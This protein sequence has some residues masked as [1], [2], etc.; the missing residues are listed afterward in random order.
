HQNRGVGTVMNVKTRIGPFTTL[1]V[2]EIAGWVEGE[3]IDVTHR[4]VI[5]GNG[6]LSVVDR[7]GDTIVSWVEELVFPW[8]LGGGL[9]AWIARP[10]LAGVWRGNL[11][12]LEE[13]IVNRQ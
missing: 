3:S 6:T 12:R 5:T 1:D 8:W 2:L 9:T 11:G 10:I 7:S 4:G 13:T